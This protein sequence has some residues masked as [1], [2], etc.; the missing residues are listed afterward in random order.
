MFGGE[1]PVGVEAA[2]DDA[3]HPP[4]PVDGGTGIGAHDG[5]RLGA[6]E[7]WRV[8]F[9]LG[10]QQAEAAPGDD[11]QSVSRGDVA[12]RP[13]EDEALAGQ[14]GEEL[15]GLLPGCAAPGADVGSELNGELADRLTI[16]ADPAD[17]GEH[18]RDGRLEGT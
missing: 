14:P 7:T 11:G 15:R 1:R 8:G 5:Q 13:E 4:R 3:G 2:H 10:A 6:V 9:V 16:G 18:G 12:G 17:V